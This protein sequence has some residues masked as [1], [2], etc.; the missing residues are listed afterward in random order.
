[1]LHSLVSIGGGG[2][3]G[4]PLQSRAINTATKSEHEKESRVYFLSLHFE[5]K[6]FI[7]FRTRKSCSLV[8]VGAGRRPPLEHCTIVLLRGGQA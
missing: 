2:A 3:S 6:A 1:M 8:L 7:W 5:T 4:L